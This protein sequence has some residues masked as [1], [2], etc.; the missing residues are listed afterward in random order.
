M[1]PD[2]YRSLLE[3]AFDDDA[4]NNSDLPKWVRN[5]LSKLENSVLKEFASLA[6]GDPDN[7]SDA[8]FAIGAVRHLKKTLDENLYDCLLYTSPS[9]RD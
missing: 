9:P 3:M 7:P 6:E 8:G 4:E 2:E 5:I 1:S